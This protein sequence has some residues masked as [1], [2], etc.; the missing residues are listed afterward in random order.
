VRELPLEDHARLASDLLLEGKLG[1]GKQANGHAGSSTETKPRV[2]VWGKPADPGRVLALHTISFLTRNQLENVHALS[3]SF[4][5]MH[6][7][8]MR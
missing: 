7:S 5:A 6:P 4:R 3:Y 8:V 1:A 2:I